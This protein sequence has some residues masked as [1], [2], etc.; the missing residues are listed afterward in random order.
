MLE[1]ALV[2][3]APK[4]TDDLFSIDW[5][6]GPGALTIR[7][8]VTKTAFV[9]ASPSNIINDPVFGMCYS[10]SSGSATGFVQQDT[11]QKP[12]NFSLPS[13]ELSVEAA[14][15]SQIYRNTLLISQ[16]INT[17][18]KGGWYLI[19]ASTG[20]RLFQLWYQD[21]TNTWRSF[22]A[23][24]SAPETAKF[25][26]RLVRKNDTLSMYLNNTMIGATAINVSFN[27]ADV[28]IAIG[29]FSDTAS[30]YPWYGKIGKIRFFVPTTA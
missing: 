26:F 18:G 12:I 13:W 3:G 11:V 4:K 14:G 24:T 5:H 9:S 8:Q 28:P 19:Y 16:A 27:N 6:E 20:I 25:T 23:D 10:Y 29:R 1:I 15:F 7:D 30:A 17:S 2:N 22:T 21:S